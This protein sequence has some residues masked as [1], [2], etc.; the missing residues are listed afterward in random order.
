M[1]VDRIID[2]VQQDIHLVNEKNRE[3]EDTK[4]GISSTRTR[5]SVTEE[6]ILKT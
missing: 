6:M 1:A 4:N 3:S 5:F 2:I